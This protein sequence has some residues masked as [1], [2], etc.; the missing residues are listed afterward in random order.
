MDEERKII[1]VDL[2]GTL[3]NDTHRRHLVSAGKW[4]EYHSLCHLDEIYPDVAIIIGGMS[5]SGYEIVLCTG[6]NEKW[7]EM[8]LDWLFKNKIFGCIDVLLMRPDD[9][10]RPAGE[11]KLDLIEKNFALSKI[12]FALDDTE[13]VIEA[14]R[15]AGIAAYQVRG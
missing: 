12:A 15:N 3:C 6:R 13:K 7:R 14:F 2:D 1:V 10:Y 5:R 8:T 9:D 4:D 11:L